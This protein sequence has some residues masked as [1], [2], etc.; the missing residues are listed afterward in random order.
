MAFMDARR[1]RCVEA[2][3]TTPRVVADG[4]AAR[5]VPVL[6]TVPPGRKGTISIAAATSLRVP[7]RVGAGAATTPV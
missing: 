1:I 4:L 2:A 5:D 7:R 3:T 6:M